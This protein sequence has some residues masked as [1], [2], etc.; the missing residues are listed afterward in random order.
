MI[1]LN[2]LYIKDLL[3]TIVVVEGIFNFLLQLRQA[4][5]CI[6]AN[7]EPV[8]PFLKLIDMSPEEFRSNQSYNAHKSILELCSIFI[9]TL[10]FYFTI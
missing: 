7:I 6:K 2:T 9:S 8:R 3:L 4:R 10:I 5:K 1:L